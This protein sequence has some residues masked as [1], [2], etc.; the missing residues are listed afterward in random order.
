MPDPYGYTVLEWDDEE[1]PHGNLRHCLR[2]GLDER[3]VSEVMSIDPVEIRL[4]NTAAD[5]VIA[6]PDSSGK[7]WTILLVKSE[8]SSDALRLVTGW[9]SS[10]KQL[11]LWE[12]AH[13][14]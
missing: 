14:R 6:G 2:H 7:M 12:Q 4:S 5:F 8:T 3:I 1:D 9:P 10:K 11:Q 13:S